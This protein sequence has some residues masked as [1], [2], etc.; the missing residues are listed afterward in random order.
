M[1][2]RLPP[3]RE[4]AKCITQC[5]QCNKSMTIK[6]LRYSHVCGQTADGSRDISKLAMEMEQ[7]A[8]IAIVARV[9]KASDEHAKERLV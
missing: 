7:N 2:K 8:V 3:C 4:A 9:K 6:S 1:H 5:P